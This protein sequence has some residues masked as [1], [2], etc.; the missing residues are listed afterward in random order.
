M[1]DAFKK[2][3]KQQ[4]TSELQ[5]LIAASKEER[6]ALSTM[7]T[8]IQLHGAK[9]AGASKSLQD[10]EDKAGKANARLNEV[11]ERL[12]K[13]DARASEL[14]ALDSR[15]QALTDAVSKA[16]QEAARLTAPDGELQKQKQAMQAL[17]RIRPRWTRSASTSGR[18]SPRCGSRPGARKT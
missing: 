10:V 15:I 9:L 13:A 16:E 11:T 3:P 14:A 17:R 18:H 4:Q 8:Q 1:L 5:S 6:A 7:L 12:A 2:G